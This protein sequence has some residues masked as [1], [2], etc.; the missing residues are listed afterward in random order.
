MLVV[1]SCLEILGVIVG[2]C[3]SFLYS[4]RG[5]GIGTVPHLPGSL[6]VVEPPFLKGERLWL[7]YYLPAYSFVC[8]CVYI[9]SVFDSRAS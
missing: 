9:V 7:F 4:V 2:A 6:P 3:Q 8:V 1:H 5:E